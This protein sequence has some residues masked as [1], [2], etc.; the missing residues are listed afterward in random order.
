M[1]PSE[2]DRGRYSHAAMRP[3]GVYHTKYNALA[4]SGAED[5]LLDGAPAMLHHTSQRLLTR[6]LT[7]NEMAE[8]R[9]QQS[10]RTGNAQAGT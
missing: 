4:S 6:K 1:Q 9:T 5:T 2:V 10:T 8:S 3:V 7:E